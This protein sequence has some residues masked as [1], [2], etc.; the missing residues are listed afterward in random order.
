M[1]LIS[2]LS[3]TSSFLIRSAAT[4][5]SDLKHPTPTGLFERRST[6]VH[7][8][9]MIS[10]D[11]IDYFKSE[12]AASSSP[13]LA[14]YDQLLDQTAVANATYTPSPVP[15]VVCGSYSIPDVGCSAEREDSLAAY[16]N[17]LAWVVSEEQSYANRAI[18]IMN[19]WSS[20]VLT[21]NDS[22]APIQSGWVG[23]V[24]ART[25][26]LI[27]Y[28]DAGWRT[29]EI[30]DFEVM[31]RTAYMP[32]VIGGSTYNGNWELV[33]T[34][35]AMFMGV[36]LE[37]ST[38]YNTAM[39]LFEARVPAYIYLTSDGSLPVYPRGINT[40]AA[41]ISYWE[42]QSSFEASGM[43]Q[44]TCRDLEH[45]GYGLASIAHVSEMSRIQGTDLYQTSVGTRL[46]AALEFHT[47][48][49][50]GIDVPS[51]L[52]SGTLDL[53]L[54]STTEIGFNAFATRMDYNNLTYTEEWTVSPYG[55]ASWVKYVNKICFLVPQHS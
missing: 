11:Q 44:E 31:L 48:F 4:A 39:E 34:E 9:V 55:I 46:Q 36:F 32:L 14:A 18:D 3:I 15:T 25:G 17:A 30:D 51:W 49:L 21:H 22:N 13:W 6:W 19:S 20:T 8:G 7:P 33:M 45:T 5:R 47:Q 42:G 52:C 54:L 43:A 40:E 29:S 23:S 16:A 41:L 1:R 10:Q 28:S 24:W 12:V 35:A 50:E 26:E 53:T 37:N 38:A 27:R 2:I